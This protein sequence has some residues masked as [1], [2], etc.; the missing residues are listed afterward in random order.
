MIEVHS[1]IPEEPAESAEAELSE[2]NSC[3]NF[4]RTY[5]SM[6]SGSPKNGCLLFM[7]SFT[8]FPISS[9]LRVI[10]SMFLSVLQKIIRRNMGRMY[11]AF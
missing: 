5:L 9:M 7:S 4:C 8:L 10:V 11:I 6:Q 3:S 1:N 2:L